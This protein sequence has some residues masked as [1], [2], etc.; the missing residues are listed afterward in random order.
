MTQVWLRII[1]PPLLAASILTYALGAGIADYLGY[2]PDGWIYIIGQAIVLLILAC[3]RILFEYS[4]L[5][6]KG[7]RLFSRRIPEDKPVMPSPQVLLTITVILLTFI[8]LLG[9]TLSRSVTNVSLTFL[10]LAVLILLSII[11]LGQPRFVYS[12]YG[13]LV[14]GLVICSLIPTFAFSIQ[15]GDTH[16][17]LLYATFP[18]IFLFLAVRFALELESYARDLKADR[19]SLLIRLGW[20][21]GVLFHHVF[22]ISAFILMTIATLFGLAWRLV[23]PALL[24]MPLA[25]Y[26]IWLVNRIALG[27]PPRWPLVKVTAGLT[28]SLPVYLLAIT[29]WLT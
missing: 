21:R 5:L 3:S 12:G 16:Q 10:Q 18:L 6:K 24:A 7:A 25:I 1:S 23:W 22:L 27:L 11:F 4:E 15:F 2:S 14:Q 28:F 9:Y 20:Q 19:R 17:L 29:F 13:E 26:E 8:V